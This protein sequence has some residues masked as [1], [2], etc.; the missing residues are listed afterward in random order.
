MRQIHMQPMKD[1]GLTTRYYD[2]RQEVFDIVRRRYVALTPEE[3]VRQQIIHFLHFQLNY[4]LELMM[5]EGRITLNGMTRR[6]DV[7]VYNTSLQPVMIVECKR[8]EVSL[9]QHV[10][11]QACRYNL[12]LRVPYLYLSNGRQHWVG[13]VEEAEQRMVSLPALPAWNVLNAIRQE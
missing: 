11:D 6:C 7:V 3:N 9:S 8:P 13:R 12:V 4:P 1:R 2:G 10:A 5:V